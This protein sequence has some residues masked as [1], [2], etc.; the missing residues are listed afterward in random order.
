MQEVNNMFD[1][2]WQKWNEIHNFW[3]G[4]MILNLT[5]LLI[6]YFY[7]LL[8]AMFT[9]TVFTTILLIVWMVYG[10]GKLPPFTKPPVE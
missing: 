5:V 4:V 3:Q 8:T 9:S 7:G 1:A 6:M 10:K 2:I